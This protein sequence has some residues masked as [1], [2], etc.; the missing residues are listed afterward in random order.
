[1]AREKRT[2]CYPEKFKRDAIRLTAETGQTTK[3]VADRLGVHP[4]QITRWKRELG[5]ADGRRPAAV[6]KTAEQL[7][8]QWLEAEIARVREERDILKKA[9]TFFGGRRRISTTSS[10]SSGACTV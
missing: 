3:A 7:R 9:G 8:I 6:R 10:K 4:N 2:A 1:M 5:A